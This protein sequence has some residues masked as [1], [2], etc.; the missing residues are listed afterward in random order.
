VNAAVGGFEVDAYWRGAGLVAEIDGFAFHSSR[1]SFESDRRRDAILAAAG[2]RVMRVTWR[3][4][5]DEPEA[6]LVLLTR[7]LQSAGAGS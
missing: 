4:I 3:Q 6:V 1:R 2:L 5:S 7:A